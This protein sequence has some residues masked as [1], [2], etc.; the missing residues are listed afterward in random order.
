MKGDYK[1]KPQK[2][3]MFYLNEDEEIMDV[4]ERK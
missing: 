3:T 2:I 4:R 1:S